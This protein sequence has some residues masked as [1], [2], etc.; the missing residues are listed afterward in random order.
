M[1]RLALLI[2]TWSFAAASI[3]QL[4]SNATQ[5]QTNQVIISSGEVPVTEPVPNEFGHG[6]CEVMPATKTFTLTD[7][8]SNICTLKIPVFSCYGY[9]ETSIEPS[10]RAEHPEMNKYSVKISENCKCCKPEELATFQLRSPVTCE[11]GHQWTGK[12]IE[13]NM[14]FTCECQ[15]CTALSEL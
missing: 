1:Y 8:Y 7:D 3:D 14:P 15:S 9:C 10:S 4:G 6:S 13:L 2:I 11:E 12:N 5:G